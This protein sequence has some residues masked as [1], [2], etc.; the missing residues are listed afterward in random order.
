MY[1]VKEKFIHVRVPSIQESIHSLVIN[2]ECKQMTNVDN[3]N[4]HCV[5]NTMLINILAKRFLIQ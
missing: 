5:K 3:T 2:N 4:K 1:F